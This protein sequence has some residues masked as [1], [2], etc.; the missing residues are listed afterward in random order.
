MST[1]LFWAS[2]A[3]ITV[4]SGQTSSRVVNCTLE[5]YDAEAICIKTPTLDGKTWS[6]QVSDDG[7]TFYTLNDLT[8]T[9]IKVPTDGTAIIYNGVLTAFK[10]MK[11]VASA[12]VSTN[13][14][15][16]WAKSTRS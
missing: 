7:I 15:F 12:G 3:D 6:I 11:L 5:C 9:P 2:L 16:H 1:M 8:G 10:F 13:L 14:L 4:A